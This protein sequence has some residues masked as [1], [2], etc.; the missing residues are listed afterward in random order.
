MLKQ[1]D[2]K[3]ATLIEACIKEQYTS[4][5]VEA[6]NSALRKVTRGKGAFPNESSVYKVLYL[7]I[8]ELKEKWK[9]PIQGWKTIQSQI[10]DLFGE[11]YTKYLEI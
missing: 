11:R 4:N 6:V 5:A 10:I 2:L 1:K 8:K 3:R 7:R 9:K